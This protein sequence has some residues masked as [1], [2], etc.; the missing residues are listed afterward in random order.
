MSKKEAKKEQE[1]TALATM[2]MS[3]GSLA[4]SGSGD[5]LS[6]ASGI[7]A[8][9]MPIV[10]ANKL[11]ISVS[12][13]KYL[14]CEGWTALLSLMGIVPICEH[15]KALPTV[16]A[17]TY[18]E[19]TVKLIR[20]SDQAMVGMASAI[21][22]KDEPQWKNRLD[23]QCRSMAITRAVS[24]AARL[25]FSWIIQLDLFTKKGYAPTPAEEMVGISPARE[26]AREPA[27]PI[28]VSN[29]DVSAFT[30]GEHSGDMRGG[31]VGQ[32]KKVASQSKAITKKADP[33]A[34]PVV[35]PK[36]GGSPLQFSGTMTSL[37]E[38]AWTDKEG[39][40]RPIWFL[41]LSEDGASD[42]ADDIEIGC[43]SE[44]I[45]AD[46]QGWGIGAK[47]TMW[48]DAPRPGKK[49]PTVRRCERTDNQTVEAEDINRVF[50]P[51]KD[52][53]F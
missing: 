11:Y 49:S 41:T 38:R 35:K 12:G 47:V 50:G 4:A 17:P 25:S 23:F 2:P 19:A 3:L 18:W 37:D 26:P 29:V 28:D 10:E 15:V 36:N 33:K 52:I 27:P 46:L 53:P 13:R 30:A 51:D 7:A 42:D 22:S 16:E 1:Q 34:N 14:L 45:G 21:C 32:R 5:I 20:V 43:F 39:E 44:T 24:K 48:C 8:Q 40:R 6:L 9:L 31:I